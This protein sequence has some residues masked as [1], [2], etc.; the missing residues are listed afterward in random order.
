MEL[1]AKFLEGRVYFGT[2]DK[3]N[4]IDPKTQRSGLNF[5]RFNVIGRLLHFLG[6]AH[7]VHYSDGEKHGVVYLNT[8]S[9]DAWKER[10]KAADAGLN[11]I[12][13]NQALSQKNIE[14][15]IKIIC[16]NFA[17]NRKAKDNDKISNPVEEK[18]EN[19]PLPQKP[20]EKVQEEANGE[21]KP[22][23]LIKPEPVL[24][25]DKNL[26]IPAIAFGK[27][28]W[29]ELGLDVEDLPLPANI[30]EILKSPCPYSKDG[31]K[32]E[33]THVLVLRPGSINGETLNADNFG[34]FMK[35]KFPELGEDG[36]RF[37]IDKAKKLGS[38]DK[39]CWMLLKREVIDG[40]R[41]KSFA[42]QQKM[43]EEQGQEKYQVP[44]ALDVIVCAMAEYAR[45]KTEY[46]RSKTRLFNNDPLTYT[47]CQKING[48]QVV[49]G[50]FAPDGLG[51]VVNFSDFNYIGVAALRKF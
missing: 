38:D 44:G 7:K 25:P 23:E 18:Q 26:Q 45:F 10:H 20:P 33:E 30:D 19:I 16:D 37:I 6:F 49:V 5:F 51:V 35:S 46:A 42:E 50:G 4:D 36:Y 21:G 12:S 8:K 27:K 31:K 17:S 43:V 47:R 29:A 40:S 41:N 2:F 1:Q 22:V 9:F 13:L 14:D 32:V 11:A 34:K 39:P 28:Q 48:Y 24:A 15:A 3:D